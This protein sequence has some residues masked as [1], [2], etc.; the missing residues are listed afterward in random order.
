VIPAVL[1]ILA[2]M[3]LCALLFGLGLCRAAGRPY[4]KDPT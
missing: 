1:L 3:W 4:P 2:A